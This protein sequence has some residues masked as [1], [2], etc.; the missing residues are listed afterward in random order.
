MAKKEIKEQKG[1]S[2]VELILSMTLILVLL[3]VVSTIFA[4]A[5]GIRDR[6]SSKTDALTAS[7]AALNVLSREISNSGYGLTHNGIV[8]ADSDES[9][10]HFRTNS[11]NSDLTI[12]SPGEDVTYF[13]D[14]ATNSIVRYDPN[15]TPQTSAVINRVSS[16]TFQYFDYFGASSTPTLSD[17]ASTNTGRVRVTVTVILDE[18]QG[19]PTGQTV[20]YTSD[21]TLRNSNYMLNQY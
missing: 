3:A 10:L 18:V 8:T 14:T 5:V 17:T 11:D 1:F 12:S 6:E 13:F 16:V 15:D 2:V 21:V 20:T 9:Q 19:Q 7:Q 4:D